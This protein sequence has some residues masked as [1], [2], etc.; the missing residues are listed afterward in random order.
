MSA[1]MINP[2]LNPSW[3]LRI[4]APLEIITNPFLF[5]KGKQFRFPRSGKKRI[6]NKWS[7]RE[8]NYRKIPDP[9]FYKIG[10]QY[11]CHPAI[12]KSLEFELFKQG[13]RVCPPILMC[14]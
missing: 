9:N 11:I 12:K 4:V 1:I 2:I 6:R 7:K 3:T 13:K 5:T 8:E 14:E 10:E